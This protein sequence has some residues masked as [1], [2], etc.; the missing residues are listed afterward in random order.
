MLEEFARLVREVEPELV[1]MENVPRVQNHA[2]YAKFIETLHSAGYHIAKRQLRCANLGLPQERRRFVLIASRLGKVQFDEPSTTLTT[3]RQAIGHLPKL[4]AGTND[5]K[6]PL[7]K[8]CSLTGLNL[9]RLRASV[10]GGTWRDWPERLRADCHKAETGASYQSVY[11][12]MEWDKPSPTITTQ[13]YKFGTGR[14]GHPEQDR[15][16]TLRE[17]AILRVIPRR[18]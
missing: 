15:A 1:T 5:P 17:A 3:V 10:P 9:S 7:H 18:L 11:A 13:S 6:D 14:F 12:R 16:I 2:P 4:A 8:A